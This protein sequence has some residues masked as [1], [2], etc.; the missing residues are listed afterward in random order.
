MGRFSAK[1]KP[2]DDDDQSAKPAPTWRCS[3]YGCQ[4]PGTMSRSITGSH[5][6]LC[7]WHFQEGEG[8]P[9]E[10]AR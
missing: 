1:T 6:W 3:V 2:A 8:A 4:S 7:R 5:R 10:H 9:L